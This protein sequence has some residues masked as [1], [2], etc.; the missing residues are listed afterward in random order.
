MNKV[1]ILQGNRTVALVHRLHNRNTHIS[2][3]DE[4]RMIKLY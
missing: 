3:L 2:I 4:V 1:Y